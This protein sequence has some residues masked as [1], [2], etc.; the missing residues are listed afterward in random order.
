MHTM[1]ESENPHS[2]SN[3]GLEPDLLLGTNNNGY[4][5]GSSISGLGGGGGGG[6][7]RASHR[8][9]REGRRSAR[10]VLAAVAGML[11]PLVTQIGHSH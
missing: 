11:L 2:P 10:L 5:D 1:Q 3:A 9:Y 6:S 8:P 7:G 4:L